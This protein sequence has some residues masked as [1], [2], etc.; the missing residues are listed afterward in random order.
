M[1][2][3]AVTA[4]EK[5]ETQ[6]NNKKRSITETKG[7]TFTTDECS[8]QL[9]YERNSEPRLKFIA[10][11]ESN[12]EFI[13]ALTEQRNIIDDYVST[14][15]RTQMQLSICKIKMAQACSIADQIK[16]CATQEGNGVYNAAIR[17]QKKT[18]RELSRKHSHLQLQLN[19]TEIHLN[20]AKKTRELI[21]EKLSPPH[22]A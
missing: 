15:V 21:I 16:V 12:L 18:I 5:P 9:L 13:A 20:H 10:D 11:R 7:G 6:N 22:V 8:P 19:V 3:L 4:T 1:K 17:D 2:Y 14:Q